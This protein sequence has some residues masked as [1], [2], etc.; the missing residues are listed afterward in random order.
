MD[1]FVELYDCKDSNNAN[2]YYALSDQFN[3]PFDTMECVTTLFNENSNLCFV[4]TYDE[5]NNYLKTYNRA[6]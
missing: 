3:N 2:L 1:T 4:D 5:N 6:M